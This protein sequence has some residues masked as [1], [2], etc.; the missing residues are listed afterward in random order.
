M[1]YIHSINNI[2]SCIMNKKLIILLIA[3]VSA[4]ICISPMAA[5]ENNGFSDVVLLDFNFFGGDDTLP[6]E[7]EN[8]KILKVN[9]K[10]TKSNGN[11]KKGT[12]YYLKFNVKSSEDNFDAYSIKIFC[13]DKKNKTIKKVNS[14]IDHDGKFKIPLKKVSKIKGAN[15]TIYNKDGKVIYSEF[16]SKLKV[17]KKVTKDDPPK[18]KSTSSS[19][20]SST[21]SGATYWGSS[22]SGKFHRP[23]CEWGQKI[24]SSNKVVF[25]SRDQ[26]INSGYVPCQVCSP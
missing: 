18:T 26:A 3:V 24:S 4:V 25:H 14:K 11:V 12:D 5:A 23:S 9:K 7:I 15:I 20:S 19:S 13:L 10:H 8:L 6:F 1:T 21:S 22:K 16:T 17:T 2:G